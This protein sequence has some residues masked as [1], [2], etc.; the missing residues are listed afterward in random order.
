MTKRAVWSATLVLAS[1]LD[2]VNITAG[3]LPRGLHPRKLPRVTL[4]V[5]VLDRSF[6]YY[7]PPGR[8][9][10]APLVIL[11]HGSGGDGQSVR[12]C[13]GYSLE[14]LA[15]RYHFVVA[16]PDGFRGNWNDCRK[17]A[18]YPARAQDIDDEGFMLALITRLV[19]DQGVDKRRVFVAGYSNG[20]QMA[21]RLGLETPERVAAIA[22]FGAGLPTDSNTVCRPVNR[23][24][25]ALIV[26]G[27]A[28][29]LNPFDGGVVPSRGSVLSTRD[30]AAYFARLD[31]HG[32]PTTTRLPHRDASD[33]TFV[34][35]S[36]WAVAG[37]AEVLL[38]VVHGGGHLIPQARTPMPTRLGPMTH[39]LDGPKEMWSFFARQHCSVCRT[40]GGFDQP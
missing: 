29:P 31:G 13:S 39:D 18:A 20:A 11:L 36:D 37:H 27:T 24:I 28:D 40:E 3:P 22:A 8:V 26:N 4:R 16:Y 15:D 23:P 30:T 14:D 21:Y 7:A 1:L 6:I 2:G 19:A 5:G 38:D 33:S 32:A 9:S 17:E 25:S 34:E 12:Y 35:R 10:G